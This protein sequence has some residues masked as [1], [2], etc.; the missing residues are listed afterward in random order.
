MRIVGTG[1]DKEAKVDKTDKAD[2]D[3]MVKEDKALVDKEDKVLAGKD[4]AVIMALVGKDSM[5]VL[6]VD[7]TAASTEATVVKE[8]S[9]EEIPMS[10]T[11]KS[12]TQTMV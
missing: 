5:V 3:S 2:K 11:M 8:D 9:T 6:T 7:S 10:P 1:R 12:A 4:K